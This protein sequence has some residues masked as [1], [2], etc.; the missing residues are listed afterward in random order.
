MRSFELVAYYRQVSQQPLTIIDVETTGSTATHSRVIEISVIH[1]SLA[2]GITFQQ[3]D[4][5]N[6]GVAVPARIT[7]FTGISTGM[8]KNAPTP[9]QV[10]PQYHP[11]L[12][13]GV[14]TAHNLMFDYGFV[15]AE[16][17]R[18]KIPFVR[19]PQQQFCTV[20]LSRL[21]LAELPSRS[22]PN[23]VRHFRF[24]INTSHRAEA[25]TLACWLLAK[26]LLT[27]IQDASDQELL[28][29]LG[30]E[31]LSLTKIAQ[32]WDCTPEVAWQRL[33]QAQAPRK[34][35]R[36]TGEYLYPRAA[37]ERLTPEP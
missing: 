5:I 19:S 32:R 37:V 36:R 28:E 29:R 15:Q 24:P 25:D 3:T 6:P 23:L 20:K 14:L 34:Q 10:W 7:D 30:K 9:E 27:Q 35:S 21:L 12:D 4:L 31:W 11:W 33:D 8:L 2:E 22:L 13:Q 26:Q 1:A 16:L 17:Q 18:V